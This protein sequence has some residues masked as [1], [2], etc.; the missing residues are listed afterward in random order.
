M[1]RLFTRHVFILQFS[2]INLAALQSSHYANFYIIYTRY[3]NNNDLH[4]SNA[5]G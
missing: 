1:T 4:L 5:P 3:I 2:H